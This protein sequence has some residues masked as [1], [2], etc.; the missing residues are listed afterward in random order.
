MPLRKE[1]ISAGTA[2]AVAVADAGSADL[3]VAVTTAMTSQT[4]GY[5][6]TKANTAVTSSGATPA[7]GQN[8][9][10]LPANVDQGDWVQVSNFTA[11]AIYVW[12]PVGWGIHGLGQNV[13]YS[14]AAGKTAAFTVV[15][16]P[17]GVLPQ[18]GGAFTF[19]QYQAMQG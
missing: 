11:N 9:L 6:I 15:T 18:G 7:S 4:N 13:T 19:H 14:L 2:Y 1:L 12:P 5:Q 17:E 10:V 16:N 3:G 8:A